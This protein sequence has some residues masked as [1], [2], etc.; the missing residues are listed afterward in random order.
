[1]TENLDNGSEENIET[2]GCQ[3]PCALT[4]NCLADIK[5]QRRFLW[6]KKK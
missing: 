4:L 2:H 3:L 6:E 1:M 5:R